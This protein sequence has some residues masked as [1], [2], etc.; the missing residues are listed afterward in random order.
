VHT[1]ETTDQTSDRERRALEMVM[2]MKASNYCQ[3]KMMLQATALPARCAASG[4]S[5]NGLCRKKG[6]QFSCS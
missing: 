4:M 1:T 5:S 6:E 2:Q 3:S